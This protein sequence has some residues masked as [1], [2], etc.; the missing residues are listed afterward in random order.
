MPL[1]K[2]TIFD[3]VALD[4]NRIGGVNLLGHHSFLISSST[5][6][7]PF[8]TNRALFLM[9]AFGFCYLGTI[10]TSYIKSIPL[11]KMIFF[12]LVLVVLYFFRVYLAI[13]VAGSPVVG[14][15]G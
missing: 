15:I 8:H 5:K 6:F 2:R 9:L 3:L 4:S 1:P 7:N 14:Q 11:V 12:L 10:H 13:R